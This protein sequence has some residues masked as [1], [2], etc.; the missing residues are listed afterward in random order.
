MLATRRLFARCLALLPALLLAAAPAPARDGK[1]QALAGIATAH[2]L[3]TAAGQEMLAAGGNAFDAA[4]AISATLAV[5]EPFASGLGGGAFWLLHEARSGRQVFVDAREVAPG[6]AT[7]GMYLDADG[8][9]VPGSTLTG[10]L[11]AGI[12]GQP[13]G[14]VHLAKRYGKLP[15]GRLLAPAIRHAEEGVPVTRGMVLGLQFRQSAAR[16]SPEFAARFYPAGKPLAEGELLRQP[17][18]AA[19]LRRLARGGFDGYYRGETARLL[20]EGVRAGG[21]IWTQ[22]DLAA[23]RVIEREPVRAVVGGV[24]VVSAPPPS[25]GGIALVNTLNMLS[26]FHRAALDSATRAHLNIEVLRRAFRDR[27]MLL[28]DPAFVTIPVARL[29]SPDYAAGQ[30]TT[31]RLDRATPSE[32]LA[33]PGTTAAG[34]PQ[35]THFSVID[36]AGNR[37]AG[38]L[39]INTFYGAAF[40]PPGTGVI[41]NNEMDDFVI[42]P[43]VANG[44][45]LVGTEANA[46]APGKRMLSSMAPTFLESPRGVAVLGT[47]GGS[48]IISMVLLATLAWI[49]GA[50]A[51]AMAA[52]KRYHHQYQPDVVAFE[53][54]AFSDADQAALR[55]LGHRLEASARPYGNMQVVTWDRATGKVEAASDP[56][57]GGDVI[58]Y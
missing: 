54:G 47:P 51:P 52:L 2:P 9:P 38:T 17:E 10:P 28:G 14:L 22:D 36:R 50:D 19:T 44:F 11:A 5:V 3:A 18:L 45:A 27:A 20:V 8:N 30:A 31:I 7:P 57:G 29:L 39:S 43:G 35:T 26:G 24:T 25:A 34:G 42:K 46:I 13:A 6:A 40:I 48:R 1:A 23:Y 33:G 49:D 41:L 32:G 56:R 53:T 16:Q 37:V 21:G 12:P 58:V 15:L 55:A 4:V